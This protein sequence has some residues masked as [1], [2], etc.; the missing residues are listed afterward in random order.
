MRKE[1]LKDYCEHIGDDEGY[2]SM[3]DIY[4]HVALYLLNPRNVF[5]MLK[6]NFHP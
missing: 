6:L 4:E 5:L 1:L 3:P 2:E